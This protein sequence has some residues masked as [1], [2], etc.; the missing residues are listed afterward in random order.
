[1]SMYRLIHVGAFRTPLAGGT[2][3]CDFRVPRPTKVF[4]IGCSL[5]TMVQTRG[6]PEGDLQ[7]LRL[8]SSPIALDT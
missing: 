3:V 4:K 5:L 8:W 2:G 6:R 7:R 1:M